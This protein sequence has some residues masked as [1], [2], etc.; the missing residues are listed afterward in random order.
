MSDCDQCE[1]VCNDVFLSAITDLYLYY[2]TRGQ[3]DVYSQ[4]DRIYRMSQTLE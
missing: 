2:R 3:I 1:W 4:E